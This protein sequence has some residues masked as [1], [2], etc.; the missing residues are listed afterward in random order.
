MKLTLV[1]VFAFIS[2]LPVDQKE[3]LVFYTSREIGVDRTNQLQAQAGIKETDALNDALPDDVKEILSGKPCGRKSHIG[4]PKDKNSVQSLIE[5][6]LLEHK[7]CKRS[8]CFDSV[9]ASRKSLGLNCTDDNLQSA[10]YNLIHKGFMTK[11]GC[12][13]ETV[14]T[15]VENE[16]EAA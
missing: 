13:N 9:R 8:E 15:F 14:L 16:V 5:N 3:A 4:R 10:S 11:A 7:K 12:L 2:S 6:Y 1:S